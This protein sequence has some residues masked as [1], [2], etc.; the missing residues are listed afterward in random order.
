MPRP[1]PDHI[2]RVIDSVEASMTDDQIERLAGNDG[3]LR[4]GLLSQRARLRDPDLDAYAR[5]FD[6]W[7]ALIE[8]FRAAS[9]SGVSDEEIEKRGIEMDRAYWNVRLALRKIE[10]RGSRGAVRT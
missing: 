1:I 6:H 5:A 10:R 3:R 7:Y 8:E 4:T 2:Q 9:A